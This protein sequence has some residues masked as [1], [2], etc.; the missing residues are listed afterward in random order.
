VSEKSEP[1]I[2]W[3]IA[4][5]TVSLLTA[6][7]A[8]VFSLVNPLESERRMTTAEDAIEDLEGDVE[9]LEA[10]FREMH[11]PE[12]QAVRSRPSRPALSAPCQIPCQQTPF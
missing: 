1:K 2:N 11:P 8:V 5:Q 6:L 9:D 4:L 3:G 12:R 7:A 10:D